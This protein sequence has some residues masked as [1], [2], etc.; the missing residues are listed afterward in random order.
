[1]TTVVTRPAGHGTNGRYVAGCRCG[2]CLAAAL[3]AQNRRSR[4]V[5]YG[6][7]QPW[8]DAGPVREHIRFLRGSGFGK[9]AIARASG[10]PLSTIDSLIYDDSP[11][12]RMRPE[13]E[14]RILA[15]LPAPELLAPGAKT[16][17]TGGR[18]RLQALIAAG[19]TNTI[20]AARL[21]ITTANFGSLLRREQWTARVIRDVQRLYA[22]MWD[23]PADEGTPRA[24]TAAAAAR[25]RAER[26]GWPLPLAWDDDQIDNPD[27]GPA[28]GWQRHDGKLRDSAVLAEEATELITQQGYDRVTAAERLGVSRHALDKAF[29]R[30]RAREGRADAA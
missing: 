30:T 9:R 16:D 23:E 14:R 7:W 21:G 1:M 10:V 20:L 12:R 26:N 17:S 24:R 13:I 2:D 3:A 5:A 18:R 27:A 25:A 4:L 15:V 11:D 29:D 8:A 22:Q 6:Q 28:E 19:H